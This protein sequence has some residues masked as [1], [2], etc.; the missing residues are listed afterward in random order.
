MLREADLWRALVTFV[1]SG[2][3]GDGLTEP[4]NKMA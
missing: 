1:M 4:I 2:M 3:C